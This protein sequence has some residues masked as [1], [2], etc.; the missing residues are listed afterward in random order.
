MWTSGSEKKDNRPFSLNKHDIAGAP[1][2][3]RLI[4][5]GIPRMDPLVSVFGER[6]RI[7]E[8][9]LARS[10]ASSTPHFGVR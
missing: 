5:I 4:L 10:S 3:P 9:A 8:W 7:E 2:T 1:D 6:I